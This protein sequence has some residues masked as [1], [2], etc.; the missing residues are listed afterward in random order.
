MLLDNHSFSKCSQK[1]GHCSG[2][3]KNFDVQDKNNLK[4]T[5]MNKLQYSEP[6]YPNNEKVN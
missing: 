1:N 3:L 6:F 4:S 2:N 5:S